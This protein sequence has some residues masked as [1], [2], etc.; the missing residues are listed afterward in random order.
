[1]PIL[2]K[3]ACFP[4]AA[5]F[6]V[7]LIL[8]T[9]FDVFTPDNTFSELE[10]RALRERPAFSAEALV[11]NRWTGDYGEYVREQFV[12]RDDWLR[13]HSFLEQCLLKLELGGV[14]LGRDG[15]LFAKTPYDA[16]SVQPV[17]DTNV[18]AICRFAESHAGNVYVMLIP[19]ASNI[20]SANLRFDPPRMDEDAILDAVYKALKEAGV[21]TIDLRGA[22]RES[23]AAGAQIFYR[24]DHHWTTDGGAL[25]AYEAFCSAA[26]LKAVIPSESLKKSVGGFFGTNYAK[27]L[28]AGAAADR[29]IYYDLPNMLSVE[30]LSPDG[31]VYMQDGPLMANDKFLTNDKYGAFLHGING[32]TRIDGDVGGNAIAT[33]SSDAAGSSGAAGSGSIVVIKDSFGNCFAPFLTANYETIAAVDMR[34]RRRIDDILNPESD[35]LV[36]YSFTMFTQDVD[37]FQ[38]G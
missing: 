31:S 7:I 33:G 19:S 2:K 35:V 1:M 12:L 30:K 9:V 38:L 25:L 5:L 3:I 11:E 21:V 18:R 6:G 16:S 20:L 15:Y 27:A 26:G 28:N 24:T 34:G 4:C 29:L 22:F 37:L 36:L 8:I 14:W 13:A 17:L 10:N 23:A 32:Y